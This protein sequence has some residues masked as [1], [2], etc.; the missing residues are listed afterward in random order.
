MALPNWW[1][2]MALPNWVAQ[3]GLSKLVVQNGPSKLVAQNELPLRPPSPCHLVPSNYVTPVPGYVQQ[4][5]KQLNP[6]GRVFFFLF[7]KKN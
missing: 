5:I 1:S 3:N 2:K 7:F 4:A 6:T